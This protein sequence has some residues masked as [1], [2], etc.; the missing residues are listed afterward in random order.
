MN[1]LSYLGINYNDF[2]W[3]MKRIVAS[4]YLTYY[5]V[6]SNGR[7]LRETPPLAPRTYIPT[8]RLGS[9]LGAPAWMV[10]F[11][12]SAHVRDL[13]Q[14]SSRNPIN[15]ILPGQ[16]RHADCCLQLSAQLANSSHTI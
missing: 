12:V 6:L 7:Q 14:L 4:I 5:V 1:C 11:R 13:D 2:T 3:R 9:T 8:K 16:A 10:G 15:A